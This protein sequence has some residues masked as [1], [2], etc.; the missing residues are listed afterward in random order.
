[1]PK[2]AKGTFP[3]RLRDTRVFFTFSESCNNGGRGIAVYA[4]SSLD[5]SIV[6]TLPGLAYQEACLL[7]I[8]L[9]G[10]DLMLFG[11]FYRSPTT[12]ITSAK[13]NESLN[14]LFRCLSKTS[15][16]HTCLVGD[17]N[18]RDINWLPWTPPPPP[19]PI[20]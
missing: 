7:E 5:K 8:R 17:F 4:H 11:C 6:H 3:G 9:R 2:N 18:F 16:T 20:M 12:S 19:P 10:G 1:M 13:N 14:Q 15:Y